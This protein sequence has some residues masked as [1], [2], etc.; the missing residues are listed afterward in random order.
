MRWWSF[1][2]L[3]LALVA[4]ERP[5]I[6]NG[7]TGDEDLALECQ[8]VS[9][10]RGDTVRSSACSQYFSKLA[11]Q[12]FD[13]SGQKVLDKVRTQTTADE[14]FGHLGVS[15]AEGRYWVVAVGHSSRISP[16]IKSLQMVQFTAQDGEKLTDTFSF[17][18]T[19]TITSE[20]IE[21]EAWM[22]RRTAM[23]RLQIIDD[24]IPTS[25]AAIR[26]D[27]RG[28]S[29]NFNPSTGQGCTKSTQS[30]LREYRPDGIYEI[31]TFP[32]LASDG[33]LQITATALTADGTTIRTRTFADV[34]VTCN[35]ITTYRGQF[36]LPGDGEIT[37]TTFGFYVNGEWLG[38]D[39]YNF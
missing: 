19:I 24:E 39:I 31:Y 36:F 12:V 8:V 35:R 18:D 22:E 33:V 27:Y 13:G 1:S 21:R 20:P 10:T 6:P 26:F 34:P 25:V 23:F 29:A 16:S 4:C 3:V 7:Y 28:G 17:C 15:L 30:E 14:A 9:T 5:M 11:L 38:E 2:F 32:Y 37:Q